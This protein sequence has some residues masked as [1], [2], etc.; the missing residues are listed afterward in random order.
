M[1]LCEDFARGLVE[2]LQQS[3]AAKE[4][5][6]SAGRPDTTPLNSAQ[7]Q[8]RW[9]LLAE[10]D[11]PRITHAQAAN[12]MMEAEREGRAIFDQPPGPEIDFSTEHEM[13]ILEHFKRPVF[14]THYPTRI[15]LFSAL[16]SPPPEGGNG[17]QTTE[18][19][20]LLLPGVAEV[21][22]GGLREHR[23]DK[24]I[25]VMRN[26]HFFRENDATLDLEDGGNYPHLQRGESL[27]SLKWFA[28]LRRYGT[29]PH[30][31]FGIGFERL[32]MYL[33]GARSTKD[34]VAFPRY[35]QSCEA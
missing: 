6:T 9:D 20:D 4:L 30:G 10:P 31:G 18:T 11:W 8:G 22:S 2:R 27:D 24:L 35:Y 25:E 33:T 34:V 13:F 21:L 17:I 29:S 7:L 12:M 23:L 28:D 5:F 16:Q 32:L 14:V 19:M 15:R 3:P 1:S 26:K